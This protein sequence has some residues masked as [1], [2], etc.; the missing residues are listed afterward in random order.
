MK[1]KKAAIEFETVIVF[2]I[3]L[4]VFAVLLLI[5]SKYGGSM[6]NSLKQSVMNAI[7]VSNNSIPRVPLPQ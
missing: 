5:F 3:V 7:S 6:Y 1:T 2:I 4:V